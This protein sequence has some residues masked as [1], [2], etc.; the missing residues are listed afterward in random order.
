MSGSS[1]PPTQALVAPPSSARRAAPG[2]R[3]PGQ[4]VG[5][6]LC[7]PL[8]GFRAS[9][10]GVFVTPGLGD[11]ALDQAQDDSMGKKCPQEEYRSSTAKTTRAYRPLAHS[12]LTGTSEQAL[13]CLAP[14]RG[15]R[16][17]G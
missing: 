12:L 4:A 15:P 6:A 14:H 16:T 8:P 2:S 7:R 13:G 5:K 11:R 1:R 3:V 9:C 17:R 10:G